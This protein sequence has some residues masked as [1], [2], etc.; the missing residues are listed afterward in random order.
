MTQTV[1][2]Q[3]YPVNTLVV[4]ADKRLSLVGLLGLLQDVAW[5][6][7]DHLGHGYEATIAAGGLWILSRQTLVMT[8]W[9]VWRDDVAIRTWVRPVRGPLVNRDYEILVG[10]R[11]IG[12]CT[13][14][15]LTMDART[16][17]PARPVLAGAPLA[18]RAEGALALHPEKIALREDLVEAARFS[19]RA[20]DL[21]L[22]GHVNNTRYAQWILD[23]APIET[24][25]RRI[26]RYGV[27]FL[28]EIQ[29]G[30]A[31]AIDGD[32]TAASS[33]AAS[34]QFQGRRLSDGAPAFAARLDVASA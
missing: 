3:S 1:W 19:A 26:V 8:D 7:A 32:P 24:A 25:A 5:L 22:N 14:S 30:D 33:G 13:A 4:N 2:T 20:S 11:K 34:L 31:V 28:A 23:S 27:N 16:R 15:W 21:D 10:D 29:V 12:E 9:P 17:R 18:W 6:H